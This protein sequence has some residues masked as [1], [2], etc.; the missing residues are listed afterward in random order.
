MRFLWALQNPRNLAGNSKF[1]LH[2]KGIGE[3][4]RLLGGRSSIRALRTVYVFETALLGW[5]AEKSGL[6]IGY[7]LHFG[8]SQ[9]LSEMHKWPIMPPNGAISAEQYRREI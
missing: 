9:A 2:L 6:S 3:T 4:P 8:E 5:A 1:Q 7:S